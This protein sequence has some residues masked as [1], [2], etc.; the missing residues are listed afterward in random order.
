MTVRPSGAASNSSESEK[1]LSVEDLRKYVQT[2]EQYTTN[3]RASYNTYEQYNSNV[4]DKVYRW[5]CGVN[6]CS[7]CGSCAVKES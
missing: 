6:R 1:L 3:L 2:I 4:T 5:L 7:S